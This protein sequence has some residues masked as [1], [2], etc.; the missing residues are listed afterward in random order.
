MAGRHESDKRELG[1]PPMR[2]PGSKNV[3]EKKRLHPKMEPYES[4]GKRTREEET[5]F[6]S[7][8]SRGGSGAKVK[9]AGLRQRRR[10]QARRERMPTGRRDTT[11]RLCS[12]SQPCSPH[13]W[14]AQRAPTREPRG[15][16]LKPAAPLEKQVGQDRR[17]HH[18]A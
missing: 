2:K 4:G 8:P 18:Q 5:P 10:R 11:G 1:S 15:S 7:G 3:L 16:R 6:A 9:E 12:S 14:H 13:S 17:E